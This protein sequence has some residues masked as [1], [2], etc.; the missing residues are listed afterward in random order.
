M[1]EA[2]SWSKVYR[3]AD[4]NPDENLLELDRRKWWLCRPKY[5]PTEKNV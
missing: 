5:K 1:L 3:T 2:E 4:D